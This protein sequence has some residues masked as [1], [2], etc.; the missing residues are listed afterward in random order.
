MLFAEKP[1]DS[2]LECAILGS[3]NNTT[4]DQSTMEE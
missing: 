1:V 4:P 3:V 2:D